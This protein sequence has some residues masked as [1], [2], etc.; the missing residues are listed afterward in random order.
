M[1]RNVLVAGGAGYIG[2]HAAKALAGQGWRPIAYDN[3]C[4]GNADAV[5]WGPL[6]E[7]DI[8][9]RARV[10]A[11]IR[12]YDIDAVMHFAAF[13]YVGESMARPE[14]YYH[15][16]LS[17]S[18][19]FLDAV[20]EAGVRKF[21]FSSSCAVYG[22]PATLPIREGD[23]LQPINPYGD[24]KLAVERALHWYGELHGLRHVSLRYFNAAGCDP[25]GEIGCDHD[26]ETRIVPLVVKAALGMQLPLDIYGTD[27]PTLDGT[28][29]RDFVHVQDLADA[30]VRAL[31][32]LDRGGA[33]IRLNLATGRGYSVRQIISAVERRSGR[34]VPWRGLPRRE[35]DPPVLYADA[36][37]AREILGWTPRLSD[38][39]S[40]IGTALAWYEAQQVPLVAAV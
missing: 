19:V 38:L 25:A 40:I 15:N 37:R 28:P 11:T 9:D 14:L 5:R 39:D 22:N 26:P 20:R 36:G 1:T 2:S 13:A 18:L 33:D 8:A 16:N 4:R 31:G 6:V 21:I 23:P 12:R 35:G 27:Y 29:V 24:S 30:H 7:G 32:Y 17:N 34:S 10:I 3:L